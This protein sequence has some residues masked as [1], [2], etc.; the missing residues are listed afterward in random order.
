MNILK[1]SGLNLS[2]MFN[3]VKGVINKYYLQNLVKMIFHL[4]SMRIKLCSF[5]M[6]FFA[7]VIHFS[8]VR[9]K[10]LDR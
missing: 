1:K 3:Y 2:K 7:I 8:D 6:E 4:A 5:A 9:K 10:L